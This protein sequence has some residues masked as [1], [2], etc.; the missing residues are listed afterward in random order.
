[1][2][3]VDGWCSEDESP[4]RVMYDFETVRNIQEY[5]C[6]FAP[7]VREG[8][9]SW[10]TTVQYWLASNVYRHLPVNSSALK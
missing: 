4:E 1:M 10:N 9:R 8:L 6:E 5:D 2:K 3:C 7:S